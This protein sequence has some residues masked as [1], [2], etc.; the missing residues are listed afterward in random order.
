MQPVVKTSRLPYDQTVATLSKAITDRGN[1]IFATIDQAAAA[2]GVGLKLRP[3][4]LIVFGNPKG[5][6][7]LM[8]AFPLAA[9][10]LPLKIV[11][12]EEQGVVSVAY[13]SAAEIASRYNVSGMD[14]LIANFDHAL[15][16]LTALVV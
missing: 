3:T 6:T 2:A 12:W 10:D 11:V 14:Q 15:D 4:T 8:V 16:S 13:T 5:G 7:G 9:L 1:T